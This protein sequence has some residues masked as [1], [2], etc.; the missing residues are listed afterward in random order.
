[1]P[2]IDEN[3]KNRIQ[4]EIDTNILSRLP[5]IKDEEIGK[6]SAE[7]FDV[8]DEENQG[9]ICAPFPPDRRPSL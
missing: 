3:I 7:G 4:T 5:F 8:E 1:M 2:A 9:L 6:L